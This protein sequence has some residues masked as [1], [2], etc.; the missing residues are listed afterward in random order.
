MALQSSINRIGKKLVACSSPCQGIARAQAKGIL[1]RCL[2]LEERDSHAM[3]AAVVGLNPAPADEDECEFY[4]SL[5]S[6]QQAFAYWAEHIRKTNRYYRAMC[7]FVDQLDLAGS[8]LWTEL[9]KCENEAGNKQ[10]PPL[11][12]FRI[13]T[14][15]YLQ[16]ELRA[17]PENWPLIA[18]GRVA[19]DTLAYISPDR[20]LIG[21]PHPTGSFGNFHRLHDEGG[22]LLA[23]LRLRAKGCWQSGKREAIWLRG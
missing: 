13:C 8:I 14:R 5:P 16:Q 19:Y 7:G 20:A 21:V 17:V 18:V 10:H 11:Q 12:T 23:E 4:R 15:T 1:P 9:V 22:S 2:Y 6:Y 3:G